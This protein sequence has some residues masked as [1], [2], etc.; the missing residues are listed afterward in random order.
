MPYTK[1]I[2]CLANS[3]K[4]GGRCI[5]GREVAAG[6]FGAW[7]RPVSDRADQAVSGTERCYADGT[8]PQIA[9]LI[10]IHFG[11]SMPHEHQQENHLIV[12]NTVWQRA[13]AVGW[14]DLQS[15]VGDSSG[16]LWV[17]GSS[18]SNGENDRVSAADAQQMTDSLCLVRPQ[19][20]RLIQRKE[21]GFDGPATIRTRASF[22]LGRVRYELRVTDPEIH[23]KYASSGIGEF[24]VDEALLTI[25]LAGL[26][27]G[28]AYKLVAAVI[29]PDRVAP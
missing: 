13:G 3:A 27:Y 16:P 25:S 29:T 24:P 9:D 15:A 23:S 6:E 5:A 1:T 8:E 14:G 7:V 22:V 20:L 12:S 10:A 28:Y 11:S 2:V 19:Q 21:G 26:F 4:P 18:S 17:D